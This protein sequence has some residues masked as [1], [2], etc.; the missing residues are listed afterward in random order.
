MSLVPEEPAPRTNT[1]GC[2]WLEMDRP[3]TLDSVVAKLLDRGRCIGA[4]CIGAFA[5]TVPA[6][7]RRAMLSHRS[8][9]QPGKPV[10]PYLEISVSG[11]AILGRNIAA[12]P[13]VE[14][15]HE[16]RG[17][18][19]VGPNLGRRRGIGWRSRP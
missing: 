3:Q 2:C 9:T 17:S 8:A 5:V 15:G 6:R 4:V 14:A 7:L 16:R 11:V 1:Q 13:L 12:R 18:S 19:W 10:L